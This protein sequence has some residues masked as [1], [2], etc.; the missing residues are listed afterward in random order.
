MASAGAP[1]LPVPL[2]GLVKHIGQH[3]ET[4]MTE[5]L[6]PYRKYEAHLRQAF[7]QD[8][9]NELLKDPHVNVL[10]LFTEDTQHIKIRARNLEAESKEKSKYIMPLS[11]QVRRPDGSPAIVQSLKEFQRNFSVFSESSLAEFDWSNVV[12]AG[13]SVVNTLIPV[14]DQYN[15]SKRAL[16]EFYHEKFCPA[17]DVDLFLY[18]LTEEQAIEKIK[19]IETRV[20]DALLT[21]TTVV[22]TKH[23]VTICS[24][25]P[26]RHIQI[27]LRIYKSVSEIL[28]G[29]DIDCSGAAYDGKQVFCTPRALQSFMTQINHI[30]LSRRSPSYENRLSKYSHRGFEV[31]WP[32]FDR[33]RIDPTIFERSFQRTLGLARL[34]VLER[35]PTPGARDFY[36]DRRREERGRPRIDRY[37]RNLRSLPGNIKESYEDEVADWFTEEEISNYH[38]FTIPY[39]VKFHAK[40]IEKLCYTRDLLLNAEWNQPDD[41]EVYL[42]RHPAFFGRFEDV[43]NDCCGYCPVPETDDEKKAAEEEEKFFV[44]GRISF[45]KDDPGRQQ[46]GS[47]N[48][49]TD[50]DW[51]EMAYV[52]NTARLCQA[53]VDGDLEHVTDWLAQEGADPNT[54]DYTGRTP[55]HLAVMSSTPE[56]VRALVDAGARLVA[57]IA[58]GRTALHLAAARGDVEI[59]KILLNKSAAN[60][61]EHEEKQ[62]QRRREKSTTKTEEA[63]EAESDGELVND[64][65]SDDDSQSMA[66]GSFVKVGIKEDKP[67]NDDLALE[68]NEE[69]PDFYD[70]NVLSWDTPC[71]ALH[72]AIVEGH[73][74]AVKTLVQEYGADV[75]LPVKFLNSEKKPHGALLTLVLALALPVEKAKE[76]AKTL[77]SLGATSA[78]A[79]LNGATAFHHFVDANAESLLE[80]L[81]ETDPVGAKTA[82]NHIAFRDYQSCQT[83]LQ[84]AVQHGNLA[85]VLKL[86]DRGAVPEIGFESW[87]K[88]AKQA[89]NM[90]NRL[91][92][93]EENQQSYKKMVEQPLI[94]ALKSPHPEIAIEL[95]ERGADPN[96]VTALTQQYMQGSWYS[97]AKGETA[98]DLADS[99]LKALREYKAETVISS[100]PR[101]PKGIDTYLENFKEGTYQHWAVSEEIDRRRKRYRRELKVYEMNNASPTSDP[102]IKEKEVAI[103]EAIKTMEKIKEALLAKGA[104]TFSEA[105]PLYKGMGP[106]YKGLGQNRGHHTT[107]YNELTGFKPFR[108]TFSFSNVYDV[109]EARKEAYFKLFNAAW[110]GDLET[111]KALTLASW[112]DAKEEAPLKIAAYDQ[113]RNNPFSLAFSRGHFKVAKAVLEIA[114]AQY[115]PEQKP[116]ARYRME[117]ADEHSE[118]SDDGSECPDDDS[119]P[120]IYSEIVDGQ[121]TID[122]VGQVSMKVNSRTKPLEIVNWTTPLST[123]IADNN[124]QGLKF[125]LEVYEHWSAQKLDPG[126]E[127]SSFYS[128]PDNEFTLAVELGRVELLGEIIKRT[129]AGLPL[130][131]LVKNTGLELQVKPEFYQGL[132]VYG[133]KREDWAT[134]GR[135]MVG[136]PGG[137]TTSPL[138]LGAFV[139]RIETVE[140]FL[141]DTP[142]RQYLAF[143]KSKA[144][145]DDVKLK[146]LAQAP[147]GFDGAISKW[148]NDQNELVLHAA[149]YA[150]PSKEATEL[151]SYLVKSQPSLLDVRAANGATPLLLA[152]RLGRLD[153]A[154]ILID[155]GADQTTKDQERNNLLHVA[156][157]NTPSVK[158]LKP[159]LDL[160]DRG[161][162]VPMLKERNKLE[163]GGRT[164]LHQHCFVATVNGFPY[165]T[166][167]AV[168][169]MIKLL[170]NIS[171]E[172]AKQAFK[173]L[174]GTGDT[175][176]HTL[177][178]KNADPTIVRA[179]INFDQS[180]LCC[181]NAVG[182]T[183][184]EVAHDIY[185]SD[186]VKPSHWNS[187]RPDDSVSSL[188]S[189]YTSTF[190]KPKCSDEP[191]EHESKT[192]IAKNWR[193]CAETM[194]RNGQP[195]R[196]LVSLNSANFVAKRL[197]Q[198]HMWARY[199]FELEKKEEE[200]PMELGGF[201]AATAGC[202]QEDESEAG[203]DVESANNV[204]PA[205]AAA[206]ARG[207]EKTK[208]RRADVITTRYTHHNSAWVRSKRQKTEGDGGESE[209]DSV[210]NDDEDTDDPE[211]E[212]EMLPLCNKCG[213]RHELCDGDD[214]VMATE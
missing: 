185:L 86:L 41:R 136:G 38:T 21:E 155:A 58:D 192:T 154:K 19:D 200:E 115:A 5:M 194:E 13:S 60:E 10:P 4:P 188:V 20:R 193:L 199:R 137:T 43:V 85:L 198:Q 204:K 122:N 96:T 159:M 212:E 127:V 75:V 189:A 80:S 23:A 128:F 73:T 146:H 91:R 59:L 77:L 47:F 207:G 44:S 201:A 99:H 81:W 168:I 130:E 126:D 214:V 197:G 129:G 178:A 22:R 147:G 166:A 7:A 156:L 120:R 116:K 161:A 211:E 93:F 74:E 163:Q 48:P 62:D 187:Y 14:P 118:Y 15:R 95:L 104:K 143:A 27:V 32:D 109:T 67:L 184:A 8:P 53:I 18:G 78:Q 106:L 105:C 64:A 191:N 97:Y 88:S 65:E 209:S 117:A 84:A 69:D 141:S 202:S 144:A 174:D 63:E 213:H 30:D 49:L 142:L 157:H 135:D 133:K 165:I 173:M 131:H 111:I 61:A 151:V 79:D 98:L 164:P 114:Q 31:Y 68:D 148:L 52:G 175:P 36:R 9:G 205:A 180:L 28:T 103:A 123:V 139:G 176:L 177:L 119:G 108:Y 183:P 102:G 110:D 70:I 51:T 203:D 195:K 55:L 124:M 167:S 152:Y 134:A 121:F 17:S 182:R 46:I 125:L 56:I 210:L 92:S 208:R 54:R 82:I 6:E 71:S 45:M 171:P 169:R 90:E 76:M 35:L 145:R 87:L 1:T 113:D 150:P 206:A 190:L 72:F 24:Q 132:T 2:A 37:H 162:L 140:W 138:L 181:E 83:P 107:A 112:D 25:Y 57:R 3:P 26:T 12:A 100:R 158:M 16:R 196:T 153:A 89:V 186:H 66:T 29:F 11:A 149:I 39:G 172:T 101:L 94:L 160:L 40:R 170:T 33:S 42:H 34:L 50:D 179:V